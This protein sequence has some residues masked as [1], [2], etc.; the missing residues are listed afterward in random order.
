VRC[1]FCDLGQDCGAGVFAGRRLG[2][3]VGPSRLLGPSGFSVRVTSSLLRSTIC[4]H[5]GQKR[6]AGETCAPQEEQNIG[7]RNSI[8]HRLPY[9]IFRR[10]R[11]RPSASPSCVLLRLRCA[12]HLHRGAIRQHLG[13]TL[14]NFSGVVAHSHHGIG[15]VLTGVL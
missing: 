11:T 12:L 6:A 5:D 3:R 1:D 9:R 4:P 15:A 13:N 8:T 7:V 2:E 10:Y 14:H